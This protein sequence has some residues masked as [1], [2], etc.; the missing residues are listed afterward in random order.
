MRARPPLFLLFSEQAH[1]VGM[2]PCRFPMSAL[3]G[4]HQVRN[5]FDLPFSVRGTTSTCCVHSSVP[6]EKKSPSGARLVVPSCT[7]FLHYRTVVQA[8]IRVYI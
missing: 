4:I 3:V 5:D 1:D 2:K 8:G 6:V 7:V